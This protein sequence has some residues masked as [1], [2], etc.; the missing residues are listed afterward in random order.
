[1]GT[2]TVRWM[3]H[4]RQR[5]TAA[6]SWAARGYPSLMRWE[7][8]R[9]ETPLLYWALTEISPAATAE[10]LDAV[11]DLLDETELLLDRIWTEPDSGGRRHGEI[12]AISTGLWSEVQRGRGAE[13]L[14]EVALHAR[15]LRNLVAPRPGQLPARP[16][17]AVP[18]YRPPGDRI[19]G[20]R[21]PLT[22]QAPLGGRDLHEQFLLL[23]AVVLSNGRGH[24]IDHETGRSP[25]GTDPARTGWTRPDGA[26][27]G[28]L[29]GGIRRTDQDQADLILRPGPCLTAIR[30]WVRTRPSVAGADRWTV[31]HIGRAL[32]QAWL[33]DTTLILEP[34]RINRTHT[35]AW[36]VHVDRTAEQVWRLPLTVY[37]PRQLQPPGEGWPNSSVP[38]RPV[39]NR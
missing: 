34:T 10:D 33:I 6:A 27:A 32:A 17:T 3:L 20:G 8:G 37:H 15:L 5:T 4:I 24:L 18:P 19:R 2:A 13:D 12:T 23:L 30:R 25:H 9:D 26:A 29:L 11:T 1:M 14:T 35:A 28:V 22:G 16:A 39:P 36:P 7:T 21:L 38:L 31:E